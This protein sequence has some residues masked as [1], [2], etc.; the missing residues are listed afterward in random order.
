M[1]DSNMVAQAVPDRDQE[2]SFLAESA[3]QAL[4][5][6][7]KMGAES[8]EVSASIHFG[9]DV[10]VR[11]GEVETLEHSRDRG[12]GI[13]VYIG[14][15]KGHASSGDLRPATIRKCVE[16][17]ID[18]AR[19]TQA[20]KCNGLAPVDRLAS[21]FPDLDLWHPQALDAKLTTQ[22]ALV[23]EAAGLEN[24]KITNSDGTSASSSFGL[25]VYA[26]S[27]GFIGRRDGTR[28]GQSCVLIGG[29]GESMQRD[30]WYDSQRAFSDLE[31]AE[32][33][34]HEAARRT[35][36]RLGARNVPTCEVPVLFAPEVARGLVGHLISAISGG[37][38]YRKASFLQ[39]AIGQRLFP[40]QVTMSERPFI[41]RGPASTAF[42]AEGVATHD[43]DIIRDGVLTGY[44]LDSYSARRL[45]LETTGNAGGVNNLLVEPGRFSAGELMQQ[46]GTGLLVTEV[47][48]QGVSIVTGDYSRGASG[49]WIENGEIQFPVDEVTIA[50]NLKDMFMRIEAVG[51]DIDKRSSIQSGSILMGKMTVAGS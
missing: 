30:Y 20:D 45:G 38:L 25:S 10:N 4:D 33:T 35:V 6:A 7:S 15:S 9:L 28:Y 13:S 26:N 39:D 23:C 49:F 27:N 44:V 40:D 32:A 22:R 50:G 17:A 36:N 21:Q 34:G 43:R 24:P 48:G 51:N 14:N 47:M 18:I 46:M 11:R 12:L 5:H 8:S 16:K 19:F 29:Q 2:L 41:L 37:S 42:D 3:Q 1:V 31:S